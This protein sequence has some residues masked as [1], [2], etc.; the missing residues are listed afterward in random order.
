MICIVSAD[1]H[2]VIGV[3]VKRYALESTADARAGN[4][5]TSIDLELR[6]MAAAHER[7]AVTR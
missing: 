3:A 2:V 1:S 6:E 7:L 5:Q 4:A